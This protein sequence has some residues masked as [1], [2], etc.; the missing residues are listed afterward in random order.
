MESSYVIYCL[1]ITSFFHTVTHSSSKFCLK[2]KFTNF[3]HLRPIIVVS[4][5][6]N[7]VFA[8]LSK[9]RVMKGKHYHAKQ[10]VNTSREMIVKEA[11]IKDPLQF[12][13]YSTSKR[14][15]RYQAQVYFLYKNKH[16]NFPFST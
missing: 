2:N 6:L 8:S 13:F 16:S 5:M 4:F 7:T 1:I 9:W 12:Y 10:N 3:L 15:R 11:E 14:I